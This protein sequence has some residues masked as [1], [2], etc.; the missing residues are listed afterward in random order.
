M[1]DAGEEDRIRDFLSDSD[2]AISKGGLFMFDN[3]DSFV[4]LSRENTS[5][6]T[7]ALYPFD[8]DAG[9]YEFWD[10][11]GQM[12]GNLTDLQMINI[13]FLPYDDVEDDGDEARMH[14]WEIISRIMRYLQ[15]KVTVCSSIEDYHPEAEEVEGLAIAI[16]GLP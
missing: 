9:S 13:S 7:V 16:H 11:V 15:H 5:V 1:E 8:S 12:V 14:D 10:K 3:I 2:L 6:G 4:A